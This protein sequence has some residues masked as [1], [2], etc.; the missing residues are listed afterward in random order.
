MFW[1]NTDHICAK[2]S[3]YLVFQLTGFY[4]LPCPPP[5]QCQVGERDGSHLGHGHPAVL[6]SSPTPPSLTGSGA[7]PAHHPHSPKV[8]H[9]LGD[10]FDLVSVWYRGTALLVLFKTNVPQVQDT[11]NNSK[12]ILGM[13]E[14][15]R[16]AGREDGGCLIDKRHQRWYPGD[17]R[18]HSAP[19]IPDWR[20]QILSQK[21]ALWA[22]IHFWY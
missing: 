19:L 11:G 5:N 21:L 7:S 9:H 12:E 6:L 17:T 15:V 10:P 4:S 3:P 8:D 14:V 20:S 18:P 13:W 2:H 16:R 1:C 22:L